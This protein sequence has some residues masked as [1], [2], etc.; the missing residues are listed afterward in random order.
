MQNLACQD[1]KRNS[2]AG[3]GIFSLIVLRQKSFWIIE[4]LIT[5]KANANTI[6]RD[7][8][9]QPDPE[10]NNGSLYGLA[11]E[12]GPLSGTLPGPLPYPI[13]PTLFIEARHAK[14]CPLTD[15]LRR[16]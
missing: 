8:K 2:Y 5:E 14:Q 6:Q 13:S 3:K 16:P 4:H 7:K 11:Q 15:L 9:S 12:S 10:L 1:N